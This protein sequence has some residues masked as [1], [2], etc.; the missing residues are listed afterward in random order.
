MGKDTKYSSDSGFLSPE[1]E[2]ILKMILDHC[3]DCALPVER[4]TLEAS[5]LAN[6][7]D[8]YAKNAAYC[9]DKGDTQ[10]PTDGGWDQVRPQ[11]TVMKNEYQ[12]ILKHSP[13]FGLNPMDFEKIF[14]GSNKPKKKQL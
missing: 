2:L 4:L 5:M 8:K 9:R 11:Y 7:F 1:G 12:N 3:K 10:K 14:K 13:K 6:S